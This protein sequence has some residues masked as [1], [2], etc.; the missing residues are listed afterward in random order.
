M[1]GAGPAG[2]DARSGGILDGDF[3]SV[4]GNAT[5][6][7]RDL[8]GNRGSVGGSSGGV[9]VIE[10]TRE[11]GLAGR[12]NGGTPGNTPGAA[13]GELTQNLVP[14]SS[15][16]LMAH[17]VKTGDTLVSIARR[18]YGD[19]TLVDRL[20]A[21]NKNRVG[22]KNSLRAGV[23]LRV[24]PKDVLLGKAR[25]PA[26]AS[27]TLEGGAT[28]GS[29]KPTGTAIK[30][31][32]APQPTTYVVKA[33]DTLGTISRSTLGTSKRWRDILE[34]NRSILD[35]EDSL[36]VGMKLKIPAR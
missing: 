33:G 28:Q 26:D 23:T 32:S 9:T 4:P 18:Y 29:S 5:I 27:P 22:P 30:P 16:K 20:A 36:T 35:D 7:T 21:Y 12:T 6:D 13:G 1:G 11:P 8:T 19:P 17:P 14:L 25:L 10:P 34:A 2:R 15:G 24:P 31:A 3:S